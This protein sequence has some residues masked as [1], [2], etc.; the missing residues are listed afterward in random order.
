MPGGRDSSG[1]TVMVE[2][3]FTNSPVP[4]RATILDY[5]AGSPFFQPGARLV[6]EGGSGADGDAEG[7]GGGGSGGSGFLLPT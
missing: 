6:R 1:D 5:F 3:Q 2:T 4:S 7:S